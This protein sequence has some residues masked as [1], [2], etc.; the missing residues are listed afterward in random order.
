MKEH[1]IDVG[2]IKPAAVKWLWRNRIPRGM[3]SVV[4]GPP[5]QGKSL[6]G[7]HVAAEVSKRGG[8][9]LVSSEERAR[10][11]VRPRMDAAGVRLGD[12]RVRHWKDAIFPDDLGAL[13]DAIR[14]Y[15]TKLVVIDPLRDHI[16][17]SILIPQQARGAL[18]PL[19]DLAEETDVAIL[20]I[21]HSLRRISP[22]AHPLG[23]IPYALAQ[24]ARAA[25]LFGPSPMDEDQ[26]LLTTVKANYS[27]I[28]PTLTF[29][30]DLEYVDGVGEV[31]CLRELEEGG[32]SL[33]DARLMLR[34]LAGEEHDP[35][36]KRSAAAEWLVY[37]LR[38]GERPARDVYEDA[39]RQGHSAKTIRR[40]S[41]DIGVIK[42]RGGPGAKWKLPADYPIDE[43]GEEDEDED[44]VVDA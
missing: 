44:D 32:D 3:V 8:V 36:A 30:V 22:N 9:I 34:A 19:E 12:G 29:D 27:E 21:L 6:L 16:S 14:T 15:G 1:T 25:F 39:R 26:R 20:G 23:A 31:A 43:L 37:Y 40:A 38:L 28:A 41:E 13:A 35:Q 17:G 11:A 5:G 33:A 7:Y 18:R 2:T 4:A 24:V 10:H 42:A